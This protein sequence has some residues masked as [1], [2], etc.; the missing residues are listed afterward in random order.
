MP[1]ILLHLAV[2]CLTFTVGTHL[3]R[4]LNAR[5][6]KQPPCQT[7]EARLTQAS[8]PYS[9]ADPQLLDIYANYAAAQTRHDSAFFE[10]VEAEEFRL[11]AD[12]RSYSRSEDIELM[13]SSTADL[14]FKTEDLK[15]EMRGDSAVVSGRMSATDSHGDVQS[16]DWIDVCVK[17]QHGWQI[18]STTQP[19]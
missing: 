4:I 14:V 17:N 16:W 18:I 12:G 11:F 13:N 5:V 1:R 3:T 2:A 15:I 19:D 8:L 6:G 9:T 10:R 7:R